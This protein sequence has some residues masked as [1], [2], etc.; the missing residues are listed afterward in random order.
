MSPRSGTPVVRGDGRRP[1][2]SRRVPRSSLPRRG[3]T[4]L[5]VFGF[6]ISGF[7]FT[8]S[9]SSRPAEFKPEDGERMKTFFP[10]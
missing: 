6:L 9:V 10:L 2:R 1:T 3:K 5:R 8:F 4:R 7:F